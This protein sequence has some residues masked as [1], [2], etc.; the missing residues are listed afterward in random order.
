MVDINSEEISKEVASMFLIKFSDLVARSFKKKE[1]FGKWVIL[2]FLRNG[3]IKTF[4]IF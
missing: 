1:K 3:R 4:T 2:K